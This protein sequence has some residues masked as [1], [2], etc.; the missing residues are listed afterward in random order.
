MGNAVRE[1]GEEWISWDSV[2]KKTIQLYKD[3]QEGFKR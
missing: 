1:L 2:A 3:L